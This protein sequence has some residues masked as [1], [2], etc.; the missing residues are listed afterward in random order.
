MARK[1]RRTEVRP[2]LKEA[3]MS[4]IRAVPS[5]R[6]AASIEISPKQAVELPDLPGLFPKGVR[7]YL[8]DLG[9][10][11]NDLIVKGARRLCDNGYIAVPHIAVRRY[12]TRARLVDRIKALTQEAGVRD[13]LVV[14]GGVN[15]PA[16]E[17]SSSIEVLEM[18]ILDRCGVTHI[19]VAGH[20]E[21]SR[22]VPDT[23]AIEALR[24]KLE[25]NKRTDAQIRIVTQFGFDAY[26]FISWAQG[27]ERSGISLPV[28]I[29]A[30]GPA[31]LTTLIKYAAMCGVGNSLEFLRKR[32]LSLSALVVVQ[33]PEAVVGP[34]ED[35]A[36]RNPDSNIR[37]IHIFTFGGV[38]KTA[39]WLTERGS[40]AAGGQAAVRV[41]EALL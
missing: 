15:R 41:P 12:A 18:G 32:A 37:Q 23:V 24:W 28:H 22:D 8:P 17:I 7:V 39:R 36:L 11:S 6:I 35:H 20:P 5:R 40:W 31:K 26:K 33:S 2:V 29:G 30:A 34:I 25:F 3:E 9:T 19:G 27:L 13:V 1:G 16:G 4:R 14:G 10:D 38:K 21:S